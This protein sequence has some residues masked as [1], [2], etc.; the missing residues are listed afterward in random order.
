MKKKKALAIAVLLVA[1]VAVCITYRQAVMTVLG[2]PD[3]LIVSEDKFFGSDALNSFIASKTLSGFVVESVSQSQVLVAEPVINSHAPFLKARLIQNIETSQQYWLVAVCYY[4]SGVCKLSGARSPSGSFYI[5]QTPVEAKE[6]VLYVSGASEGT[7]S[8]TITITHD[9][10]QKTTVSLTNYQSYFLSWGMPFVAL[11]GSVYFNQTAADGIHNYIMSRNSIQHVLLV[12]RGLPAFNMR[13]VDPGSL[14]SGAIYCGFS[15]HPYSVRNLNQPSA[16]LSDLAVGRWLV[17]TNSDLQTM[18]KKS[19]GFMPEMSHRALFVKGDA[20][21]PPMEMIWDEYFDDL[22]GAGNQTLQER[23]SETFVQIEPLKQDL[24]SALHLENDYVFFFAHGNS[25]SVGA[26][27]PSPLTSADAQQSVSFANSTIVWSLACSN[28]D[29]RVDNCLAEA[30][31]NT[32][33]SNTTLFLGNTIPSR[34]SPSTQICVNFF[35]LSETSFGATFIKAKN[36]VNVPSLDRLILNYF[37]DPTL[38]TG[39]S[40]IPPPPPP[41]EQGII[42]VIIILALLVGTIFLM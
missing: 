2:L 31:L 24:I 42:L 8:G 34:I 32:P 7:G 17:D 27:I 35:G 22:T 11:D 19:V 1:L 15:D 12:G 30:F 21:Y 3:Y 29:F 14:T 16:L 39:L 38:I 10:G 26:N 33:L 28:G 23:G 37:G 13:W 9:G 36:N 6:V 18:V 4:E 41:P 20:N 25:D 40:V 5:G